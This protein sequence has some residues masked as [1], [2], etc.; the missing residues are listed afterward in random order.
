MA[1]NY[2]HTMPF[3]AEVLPD[4]RV[5]FQLWAPSQAAV[6][7]VVEDEQR[8][9]PMTPLEDGFFGL[10]TDAARVGSRYRFQLEDGFRVPDPASRWQPEDVHG[11]SV[12]VDPR[13]YAWQHTAW[14]G[15]PWAE[16]VLYELHV[17]AFTEEGTFDGVR[18]K[19][20]SP[21][22]ARRDRHRA[23]AACGVFR[24]A[25][26]GLRRRHAVCPRCG[27]RQPRR[28]QAPDRRGARARAHDVPRRGVQSL[29]P[30]G[31]L[32]APVR[33]RASSSRTST[34]PGARRSI[35]RYGRCA[36]SR[37][38][39]CC[40]GS[41]SSASTACASTRSTGSSTAARSTS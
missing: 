34:R 11:P 31:E 5:R 29:R 17:G 39:T 16:A 36:S 33:R 13:A 30:R 37:C 27:L 23:D 18:R 28:P 32:P 25:Q 35:T 9:L 6:A 19:L 1:E 20:D 21:G 15:R 8:V 7:L 12:V 3:G 40:T 38:T 41:R 14:R 22:R 2:F 24:H 4:G 10:T 26:L